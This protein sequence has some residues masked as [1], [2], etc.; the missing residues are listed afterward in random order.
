ML[1]R[2]N[3]IRSILVAVALGLLIFLALK[4]PVPGALKTLV[5]PLG[6]FWAGLWR[7][8]LAI[9]GF[10]DRAGAGESGDAEAIRRELTRALGRVA[11][12]EAENETLRKTL[13]LRGEL[14]VTLVPVEVIGFAREGRDEYLMLASGA[15]QG[16]REGVI[17]LDGAGVLAGTI[18]STSQ[19]LAKVKLLSSPSYAIEV[20]ILPRAGSEGEAIRPPVKALARGANSRELEIQLVPQGSRI[21]AGDLLITRE[22]STSGGRRVRLLV[23]EVREVLTGEHQVFIP[24]RAI[25]SFDPFSTDTVFVLPGASP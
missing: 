24:I 5:D 22:L 8:G 4:V 1:F 9:R 16:L 11:E 17:V 15:A 20:E 13:Q 18:T 3:V 12:L 10:F 2:K 14:G 25:H 19:R 21:S 6:R 23:G 7:S